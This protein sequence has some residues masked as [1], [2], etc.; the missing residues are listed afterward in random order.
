VLF[1]EQIEEVRRRADPNQAFHRVEDDVNLA[2]R[3]EI[4]PIYHGKCLQ[5][6]HGALRG[7][8]PEGAKWETR[9]A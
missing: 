3:H 8:D 9:G 5:V 1:L 7:A 6:P 2:L 4:R